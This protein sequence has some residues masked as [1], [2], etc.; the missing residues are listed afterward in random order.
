MVIHSKVQSRSIE[1]LLDE[2]SGVRM[3]PQNQES[4]I[5]LDLLV[6]S[7]MASLQRPRACRLAVGNSPEG[8]GR[9]TW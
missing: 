3:W 1:P 2:F 5:S 9:L 4:S 6:G 8:T 7:Q